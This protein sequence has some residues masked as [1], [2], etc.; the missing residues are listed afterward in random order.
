MKLRDVLSS[1]RKALRQP[2]PCILMYHRVCSP[3]ID[4]WDLAVSNECFE[5]QMQYLKQ[6]RTTLAMSDFV[7]QLQAGTLPKTAVAIT[8]DDGYR[9]NL[10]NARP[11]L[12][13]HGLSAT[14]FLA[15]GYVDAKKLYWWDELAN[16]ILEAPEPAQLEVVLAGSTLLVCWGIPEED[17]LAGS[18]QA[19]QDPRTERQ[20][21]YLSLWRKLKQAI[22]TEQE[23]A[24]I[25]LRS[26]LMVSTD[27]LTEPMG[28][29]EVTQALQGGVF[30]LGA[31]TVN[32]PALSEL[33]SNEARQEI[34]QSRERC[35]AIAAATVQGFAYP[36]GA[37]GAEVRATVQLLGFRWACSTEHGFVSSDNCK[38]YALPRIAATNQSLEAFAAS[39]RG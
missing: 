18:W 37:M 13:R 25:Y 11:V 28:A 20:K 16:M 1:A 29:A 27:S 35:E 17:D 22:P 9:D 14:L 8:F 30:T 26:Q 6:H 36:Y 12:E 33:N 23:T 21:A 4:P 2:R 19:S 38:L 5:E 32:H 34:A 3:R 10:V 39:L 15:T 31:H 24:L 7:N